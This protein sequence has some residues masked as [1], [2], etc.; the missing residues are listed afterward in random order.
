[1]NYLTFLK[2]KITHELASSHDD[3]RVLHLGLCLMTTV[4]AEFFRRTSSDV[5]GPLGALG[6]LGAARNARGSRLAHGELNLLFELPLLL[7]EALDLLEEGLLVLLEGVLLLFDVLQL[8]SS[9]L[10]L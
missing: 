2:T 5:E 8:P 9:P 10:P 7:L 4:S 1:M 6:R 3:H